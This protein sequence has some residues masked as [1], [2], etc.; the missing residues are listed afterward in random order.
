MEWNE[1][2]G[3]GAGFEGVSEGE[4]AGEWGGLGT[5]GSCMSAPMKGEEHFASSLR[6]AVTSSVAYMVIATVSSACLRAARASR[7][8]AEAHTSGMPCMAALT[9]CTRPCCAQSPQ[10]T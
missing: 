7:T 3:A 9:S 6:R 10:H 5:S 8:S 2:E 1:G 4:N